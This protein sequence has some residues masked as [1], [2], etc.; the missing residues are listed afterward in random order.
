MPNGRLRATCITGINSCAG[1]A[2]VLVGVHF[3]RSASGAGTGDSPRVDAVHE[4]HQ[5]GR[6]WFYSTE[7]T[8][9]RGW[10]F[11]IPGTASL[12]G[13]L[14]LGALEEAMAAPSAGHSAARFLVFL[15]VECS[16]QG[17]GCLARTQRSSLFRLMLPGFAW[18]PSVGW[19]GE[20]GCWC[21]RNKIK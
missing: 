2:E 6:C 8:G 20:G 12:G 15:A 7:L 17:P 16:S 21:A 5:G 11:T 1:N 10:V 4:H 13:L 9:A 18:V 19:G 3:W 14:Q